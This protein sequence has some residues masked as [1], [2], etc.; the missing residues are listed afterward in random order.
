MIII[1]IESTIQRIIPWT[2]IVCKSKEYFILQKSNMQE[3]TIYLDGDA[4]V[5]S[6]DQFQAH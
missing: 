1:I 5:S 3:S 2:Q 4:Q 6:Q